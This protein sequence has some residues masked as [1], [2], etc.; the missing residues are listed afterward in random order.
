MRAALAADAPD[1]AALHGS[2]FA[3]GWETPAVDAMLSSP[4]ASAFIAEGRERI[5]GFLLGRHAADEAEILSIAVDKTL[6]RGGLGRAMLE[7]F[8]ADCA[9]RGIARM[10]IEVAE[11]DEGAVAF[12]RAAGFVACGRRPAYYPDRPAGANDAL[13]MRRDIAGCP[14]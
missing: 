5:A 14:S 2:S 12:Y 4:G 1:I 7:R 10:F 6:R 3:K 13:L 11:A 9:A 8:A